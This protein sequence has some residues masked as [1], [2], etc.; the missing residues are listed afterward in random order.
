VA[1]FETTVPVLM[2]ARGRFI[3]RSFCHPGRKKATAFQPSSLFILI[4]EH[5]TKCNITGE[6]I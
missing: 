5:P 2:E 6:E 4:G 1:T 3:P